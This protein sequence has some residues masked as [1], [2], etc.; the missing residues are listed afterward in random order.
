MSRRSLGTWMLLVMGLAAVLAVTPA[1]AD[2][3][4]RI[5]RLSDVEGK[6]EADRNTGQG[7][8]NAFLNM[9]MVQGMKL[10]TKDGRAEVEFED[11]STLRLT[12]KTTIEFSDLMLR[13]SGAR[14]ST[15]TVK[16]GMVYVKY[17]AKGKD[18]EFTI[19]FADEKLRLDQATHFRLEVSRDNAEL[20]VFN[21]ELKVDGPSGEA[22]VSKNRTATFD[23]LNKE[24]VTIA[25][26]VDEAPLDA[27]DKQQN[28]YH[29]EYASRAS[30]SNYPYGYGVSDLNYYGN[31]YDVP[32]YG[33]MWQPYFAGVSWSPFAD[34]CWMFY[35]GFGWMWVSAYPWGWMPYRYGGWSLVP[36]YGWMWAAGGWGG[37]YNVPPV[38]NPPNRFPVPKP[39]VRGTTTVVVGHPATGLTSLPP[40]RLMVQNGTAGLGIPRGAVNNLGRVSHEVQRS[41]SATVHLSAPYRGT[42]MGLSASGWS[43]ASRASSGAHMSTG[44]SHT[45]GGSSG[46]HSSAG[47][48]HR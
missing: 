46:G 33:W 6:V 34:G 14:V 42:S 23:L 48:S 28:Q 40:Q 1:F 3:Q 35:P 5:V 16:T 31:Y 26:G 20:A 36:G 44:V 45:G 47:S 37:W 32:G 19:R 17:V 27:W 15:V 7:F 38:A 8:E 43:G 10:A 4:V 25:K 41:G 11:G 9:P 29:E 2:S 12:S 22:E 18:D 24:K 39:P 13:D 30:N 21:G